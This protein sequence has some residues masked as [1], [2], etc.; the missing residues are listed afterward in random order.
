MGY[1]CKKL[2][3][4]DYKNIVACDFNKTNYILTSI[5]FI[6][7]NLN[8]VI[9]LENNQFD[10]SVA[11]E[12]I[13]HLENQFH[14]IKEMM[15]VTKIGGIIIITTPNITSLV[16]RFYFYSMDFQMQRHIQSIHM[17]KTFI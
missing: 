11:I 10:C 4:G 8:E 17:I 14:F 3:D 5:P 9:P 6:Q 15:R 1:L 2:L 12:V 16:S 13:E 7:T